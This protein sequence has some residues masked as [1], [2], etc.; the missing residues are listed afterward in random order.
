[1]KDALG[2]GSD[3]QGKAEQARGLAGYH[4]PVWY[5]GSPTGFPGLNGPIHVGTESAA[6]QALEARI[7]VPADLQGWSGNREYGKT[8]LAGED[9][10]NKIERGDTPYYN[11]YPKSG[12]NCDAPKEDYYAPK[13]P[14]MGGTSRGSGTP[15]TPDMRP[16]VRAYQIN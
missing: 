11:H 14:T 16:A 10:L 2:H 15:M 1:M 3:P 5:H 4:L 7:G 8:L 9:T 12:F 13:M 6:R